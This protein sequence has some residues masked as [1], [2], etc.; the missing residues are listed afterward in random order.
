MLPS[1]P[2]QEH[3]HIGSDRTVWPPSRTAIA[4]G[5]GIDPYNTGKVEASGLMERSTLPPCTLAH[6]NIVSDCAIPHLSST[7]SPLPVG[8]V[9]GELLDP[10]GQERH[11]GG[12]RRPEAGQA[13]RPQLPGRMLLD[14]FIGHEAHVH[15]ARHLLGAV[16]S[17]PS[18]A[19]PRPRRLGSPAEHSED[20]GGRRRGRPAG[21]WCDRV[22][23]PA[24]RLSMWRAALGSHSRS[25][26]ASLVAW[27]GHLEVRSL[28]PVGWPAWLRDP[29]WVRSASSRTL[30]PVD[31]PRVLAG[32][33]VQN[34]GHSR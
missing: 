19:P 30:I 6:P 4:L 28:A 23:P 29:L 34:L 5:A 18:L 14:A 22:V 26:P 12:D 13:R 33:R 25:C 2:G 11:Q 1:R 20:D 16:I 9:A 10:V 31:Q 24:G 32:R 3:G 8:A 15:P 27:T 17:A 7:R 21:C